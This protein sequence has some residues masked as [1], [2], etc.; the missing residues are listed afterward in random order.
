MDIIIII[1]KS[2]RLIQI[3]CNKNISIFDSDDSQITVRLL[4]QSVLFLVLRK[5]IIGPFVLKLTF[6]HPIL[7]C[8]PTVAN[9][10]KHTDFQTCL[11]FKWGWKSGGVFRCINACAAIETTSCRCP[12]L[13]SRESGRFVF[14]HEIRSAS[15]TV[16]PPPL[17]R[18]E[19]EMQWGKNS[20]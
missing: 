11:L 3:A 17:S 13:V 7:P 16:R 6:D 1:M 2:W 9:L 8:E 10:W 14:M 4:M 12:A 5:L 18:K 15:R 19:V 20:S